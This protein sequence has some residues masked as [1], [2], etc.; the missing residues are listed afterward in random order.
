VPAAET[1]EIRF[2]DE[3]VPVEAPIFN[4]VLTAEAED[5]SVL[6]SYTSS[7][8]AGEPA[9]TLHARGKGRVIHFGSFFTRQNTAALLN[10]LGI[11][12]PIRAWVEVPAAIEAIVRSNGSEHFCLLMNFTE[13][14]QQ[15]TFRQPALELLE[16]Q[17][18]QGSAEIP[19]YGVYFVRLESPA[20]RLGQAAGVQ[21]PN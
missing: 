8:Y 14:P 16:S 7:Y 2:G 20:G 18:L 3:A 13:H 17:K 10:A 11:D 1:S 6:A 9:V 4:E 21:P 15:V 5:L 19:A 12:D